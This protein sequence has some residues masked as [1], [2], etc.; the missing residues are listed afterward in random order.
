MGPLQAGRIGAV[1]GGTLL[2]IAGLVFALVSPSGVPFS[3][4]LSLEYFQKYVIYPGM[5]GVVA[6]ALIGS[7]LWVTRTDRRLPRLWV[8]LSWWLLCGTAGFLLAFGA[9]LA[10]LAFGLKYQSTDGSGGAAL[11]VL[12]GLMVVP[13]TLIGSIVGIVVGIWKSRVRQ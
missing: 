3:S 1:L 12:L 11:A 10:L 4:L 8:V 9:F 13:S 6:G 7:A 5:V 2:V